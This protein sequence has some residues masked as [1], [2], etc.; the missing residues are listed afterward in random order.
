[1]AY[2]PIEQ[3]R[4]LNNR[5]LKIIAQGRGVTAAQVALAW[6]LHQ[7]N[8]IAIPKSSRID[9]IEQNYAAMNLKLSADELAAGACC[10]STTN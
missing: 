9:H 8:V 7:D 3:G 10:L 1:M 5:T 2:S 4:L 6:V